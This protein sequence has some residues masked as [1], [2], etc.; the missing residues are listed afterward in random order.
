[1][2]RNSLYILAAL[3]ALA[4]LGCSD[5]DDPAAPG[6][7]TAP[8]Q[9]SYE[10]DIQPVWDQSC[11]PGCHG[12]SGFGGLDLRPGESHAALVNVISPT[13]GVARVAPADPAG[14]VLFN[15]ITDTGTYGGVMPLGGPLLDEASIELIRAWILAGA[16]A[17]MFEVGSE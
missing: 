11:G 14:S 2:N 5:D 17:G 1:M 7:G 16:P 9:A 8:T 3:L 4:T 15:K 12:D 10:D 13:Y 6:D